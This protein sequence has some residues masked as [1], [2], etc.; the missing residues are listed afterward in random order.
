MFKVKELVWMMGCVSLM[1]GCAMYQSRDSQALSIKP[2]MNV[3]HGGRFEGMY[4]LGRYHQGKANYTQAIEAYEKALAENRAHAETHNRLGVCYFFQGR[5]ELALQHLQKAIELSPTA[6]HLHSNLG[7]AHL[8]RGKEGEAAGAFE[9][10][11]RLDPE[12]Q[13][14][15]RHL[16][17]V[18]EKTG[19][20]DKAAILKMAEPDLAVPPGE[21]N[22]VREPLAALALRPPLGERGQGNP[23]ISVPVNL[24]ATNADEQ[25]V[26]QERGFLLVQITPE[27]FE[28]KVSEDGSMMASSEAKPGG[29]AGTEYPSISTTRRDGLTE[30][31]IEVSNGNGVTGMAKKVSELLQQ[32]GFAKARLTDQRPF[33]QAQTEI[34]Y[35]PGSY[36]LACQINNMIPTQVPIV[37]SRILRR[38]IQVR[39][40]LGRDVAQVAFPDQRSTIQIA[41]EAGKAAI[42]L[43]AGE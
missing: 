11:L 1:G 28:L 22:G 41:Q 12:N 13:R 33:Q 5:R 36:L 35:R 16:T 3:K 29:G 8:L 42:T 10:A 24:I 15:R 7:Y 40:V 6:S 20:L 4:Q 18:Y 27:V 30:I 31:S 39:M 14:A 32:N 25:T 23:S 9:Q 2:I 34:Q 26:R 37:E 38:D 43:R 19:L 21:M 17:A